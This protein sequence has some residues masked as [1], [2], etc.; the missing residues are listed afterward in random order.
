MDIKQL[1]YDSVQFMHLNYSEQIAI[2]DIS[3]HVYLSPSYYATVFRVLT[4][5]TVK[6]Y[7]NRYRLHRAAVSLAESNK[8][9]I[10]I[11]FD[12]GFLSQQSFTKRFSQAY[13]I[14]PAQ[15]RL[16]K[17][18]IEPFPPENIWKERVLSMELMDCFENVQFIK[19]DAF[20]VAGLEVDINYND[21]NGTDP[22]SGIWDVWK[23]NDYEIPKSIPNIIGEAVYGM[24]HSENIEGTAK[25]MVGVPVSTL[26]NLP[27]SFVGRKFE[28]SDYA[29]FKTTLDILWSGDFWRT[30]YTK[31]LPESGYMMH[32]E[33]VRKS[34]PT[35]NRYPD[36][37]VYDKDF[38]DGIMY[39][40]A[41]VIKKDI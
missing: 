25:Y 28:T 6:H 40:Y 23:N 29:V 31:W 27:V 13:G 20:Y 35:F 22:I 4:G 8:R 14:S 37:E 18:T 34:Y 33:Q 16:S 1:V 2:A 26:D 15:F 9:I 36:I 11:A 38:E 10:E 3:A 7:L 24:T 19:K 21:K 32:D 17:P 39:I 5:Y 41:P 30:F 12:S